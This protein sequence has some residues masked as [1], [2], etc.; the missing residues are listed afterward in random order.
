MLTWEMLHPKM[1]LEHIGKIPFWLDDVNPLS[2]NEQI[3]QNYWHG[4]GWVPFLGFNMDP[5][6]LALL[7]PGDTSMRLSIEKQTDKP[8]VLLSL[9]MTPCVASPKPSHG[10]VGTGKI[11]R[12]TAV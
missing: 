3:N 6:T 9:S 12:H 10:F 1:T 2:A 5:K 7:Y 8:S 4:G 11:D